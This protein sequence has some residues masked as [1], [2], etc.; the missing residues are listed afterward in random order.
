MDRFPKLEG[1]LR[2]DVLI[3]GGGM[4]GVL[5][6]WMLRERGIDCALVEAGRICRGV[7]GRTTAKITSQHGLAYHKLIRRFGAEKAR[8]YY[9]A[10]QAALE[11]YRVL[12]RRFPCDL[13]TKKNGVYSVDDPGKLEQEWK[14]LGQLGI[15][16]LYSEQLPVPLDTCGG[17]FFPEQAQFHPLKLI[18]GIAKRLQIYEN[19]PARAF[20]PGV[21][22]TDRGTVRAEKIILATHFPVI[23]KHGAY[24]LKL[25]QE[26]SYVIALENAMDVR[27]MYL[28]EK[29]SGFSFR[30]AGDLLLLGGGS[31]RTGKPTQG[32]KPLEDFALR[33][34]PEA[35]IRYRWA[36]QDCMSLDGVPYIGRYSPSTPDL[37]VATGFNKWGMSQSMVAAMMLSDLVQGKNHP[38]EPLFAPARS[39]LR[40]QLIVNGWESAVHLLTPVKP[41]CPHMGCALKWNPRE[42]SWDCPCHGSRF[43]DRGRLLENPAM[44][45]MEKR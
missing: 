9:D 19:T 41:R 14:A 20:A 5:C 12:A 34:F 25:Y 10:N 37:Y 30:N 39:I 17:I 16:A 18:S 6:A 42:H 4:A 32:W 29:E 36:T 23:N 2:T 1:D 43:D 44:G 45:N 40:P 26:R 7:T 21:V 27:G 3:V 31:H 15:P 11:R 22:K 28:D 24:F 35:K 38:W 8:M 13:E 33:Q